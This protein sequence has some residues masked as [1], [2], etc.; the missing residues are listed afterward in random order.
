[1]LFPD[2]PRVSF[3]A[4]SQLKCDEFPQS[5]RRVHASVRFC[6]SYILQDRRKRYSRTPD[7]MRRAHGGRQKCAFTLTSD[8]PLLR[9][10]SLRMPHPDDRIEPNLTRR[11]VARGDVHPARAHVLR[12]HVDLVAHLVHYTP[13]YIV[14]Y[15]VRYLPTQH[16]D[17]VAHLVHYMVHSIVH[18]M[19]HY[20]V[21]YIVH[22][23]VHYTVHYMVHHKCIAWCITWCIPWCITYQPITY[24][25]NTL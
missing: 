17:L 16:V 24:L 23:T 22:C 20:M 21:Q 25:P 5:Q 2:S 13:H 12:Q 18:H 19:V 10:P 11:H 14:H 15:I 9:H 8:A 3:Q 7:Y 4:S 6:S 1:M